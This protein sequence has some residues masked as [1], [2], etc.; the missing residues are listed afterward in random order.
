MFIAYSNAISF[1]VTD[2]F[3]SEADAMLRKLCLQG[4]ANGLGSIKALELYY[5]RMGLLVNKSEVT[6]NETSGATRP[7]TESEVQAKLA[8]I[9]KTLQ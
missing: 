9:N 1:R 7:L 8:E 6:T 5:K 2:S 4:G 3:Q